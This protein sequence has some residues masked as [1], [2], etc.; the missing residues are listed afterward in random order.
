M[1]DESSHS[2]TTRDLATTSYVLSNNDLVVLRA[3]FPFLK[4][5]R[6]DF[7][8]ADTPDCLIK[9]ETANLKLKEAERTKD[10]DDKLAHNRSNIGTIG[11]GHRRQIMHFQNGLFLPGANSSAAKLYLAARERTP[12]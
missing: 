4:D 5:F 3:K 6:D 9:L 11:H 10:A 8:R 12:L 7:I 2:N 1:V